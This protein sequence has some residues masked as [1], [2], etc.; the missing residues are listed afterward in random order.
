MISIVRMND[1]HDQCYVY[2]LSRFKQKNPHLLFCK[3]DSPGIESISREMFDYDHHEA[4]DY[5]MASSK[6]SSLTGTTLVTAWTLNTSPDS[7]RRK[8]WPIRG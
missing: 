5:K 4:R 3:S 1:C 2:E 7:L 8:A 6:N